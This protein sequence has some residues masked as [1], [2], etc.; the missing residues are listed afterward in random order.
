MTDDQGNFMGMTSAEYRDQATPIARA[1]I[2]D[3]LDVHGGP[4]NDA[5]VDT[6]C[7]ID[8]VFTTEARTAPQITS[9][10][11]LAATATCMPAGAEARPDKTVVTPPHASADNSRRR[12]RTATASESLA[13]QLIQAY[14]SSRTSFGRFYRAGVVAVQHQRVSC[15]EPP[16]VRKEGRGLFPMGLPYPQVLLPA[17]PP[18]SACRRQR[19]WACRKVQQLT[20]LMVAQ[21]TWLSLGKPSKGVGISA[22]GRTIIP[23]AGSLCGSPPCKSNGRRCAAPMWTHHPCWLAALRAAKTVGAY[24]LPKHTSSHELAPVTLALTSQNLA[25]PKHAAQI[26][27][28]PPVV[29]AF[30]GDILETEGV[31]DLPSERCL[32][33]LEPFGR[34]DGIE[35][36]LL[37]LFA[38]R[39]V[40]HY[41]L[42]KHSPARVAETVVGRPV[43]AWQLSEL[44]L[45]RGSAP[46]P[47]SEQD[48]L[49]LCLRAPAMGD[50]RSPDVAQATHQHVL[51]EGEHGDLSTKNP[52]S[53]AMHLERWLTWMANP[54]WSALARRL[55]GRPVV[56]VHRELRVG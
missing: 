18:R 16:P 14:S 30:F 38:H 1:V 31:F 3:N 23:V 28:Q 9:A 2:E 19:F 22:S 43:W 11:V 52:T 7:E 44:A 53:V 55:C 13:Q 5:Q 33:C 6:T 42:L 34:H 47:G 12:R 17:V 45:Q 54:S 56:G 46:S 41:Y 48:K 40:W 29:P 32:C 15:A 39:I 8:D 20:N 10:A 4:M 21:W 25:L 36:S 51:L 24:C 49:D 27:L 35:A 26:P 37:H 50:S